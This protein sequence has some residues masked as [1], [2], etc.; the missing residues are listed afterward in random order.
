MNKAIFL[1]RDGVVNKAIV[2]EGKPYPPASINELEI[3]P[4]VLEGIKILK[5]KGF[6]IIIVTNQPDVSRGTKKREDIETIHLHLQ[7]I[8][9]ID[10]IFCCF[11]DGKDDCKCRKPKPG[12]ILNASAK[13]N[14]D[15]SRSFL[16]GDR[17]RDIEAASAA[18]VSSILIEYNYDEKKVTPDFSCYD[19]K[20]AVNYILKHN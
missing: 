19:F 9:Q 5:T 13:W 7:Q 3:A 4:Y 8:L 11:H 12:M 2:R 18:E 1:D 17:W 14:I 15:R 6:K 10:D 16:I 20:N